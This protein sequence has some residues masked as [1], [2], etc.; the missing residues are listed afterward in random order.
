MPTAAP[1]F[2]PPGCI[3][4]GDSPTFALPP[5][6]VASLHLP[7][8]VA[9]FSLI[10]WPSVH[11]QQLLPN[12]TPTTTPTIKYD[13]HP[14]SPPPAPRP[15]TAAIPSAPPLHLPRSP[16][17]GAGPQPC[18]ARSSSSPVPSSQ[19]LPRLRRPPRP[20]A[21]GLSGS[22]ESACRPA[23]PRWEWGRGP[24]PLIRPVP[25]S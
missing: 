9:S 25:P 17:P 18:P 7:F 22:A 12:S 8:T 15:P 1:K 16:A 11:L 2:Y 3:S 6:T 10:H 21:P 5:T 20:S 4:L 19:S 23:Q 13:L 24:V 14:A